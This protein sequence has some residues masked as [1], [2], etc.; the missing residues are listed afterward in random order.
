MPIPNFGSNNPPEES[1]LSDFWLALAIGNSR[2]HW[3]IFAGTQLQ[4]TWD[5]PHLSLEAFQQL[6]ANQFD[7]TT[8]PSVPPIPPYPE[9]WIASV[10]PSQTALWQNYLRVRFLTLEQVPLQK[11]YPTFGI[12]RALSVWGALSTVGAPVLV[13]D[14]G[15]AL[16]FTGADRNHQLIGGAILPGLQLQFQ[17]LS[18]G[19]AA[20]PEL[21][22]PRSLLATPL[23]LRWALDTENAIA[24]GVIHTLIAGI[25]SFLKDWWQQFPDSTVVF[26][27]GDGERLSSYLKQQK[28]ELAA[29]IIVNPA[30]IFEG[31]SAIRERD[32]GF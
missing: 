26:T 1:A 11:T 23:P 22:P 2:V 15:T 4:Q 28:P 25:Q 8:L 17:A 10:V 9:L 27:G 20:L 14:A 6:Q 30:V 12:D 29:K 32:F 5:T 24:S 31:I 3:A 19:T 13:I 7:F 18:Q 16:T 21:P